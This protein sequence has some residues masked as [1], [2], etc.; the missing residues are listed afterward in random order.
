[1][2]KKVICEEVQVSTSEE[3]EFLAAIQPL[4]R[5]NVLLYML[6]VI[7]AAKPGSQIMVMAFTI[8]HGMIVR[9]LITAKDRGCGVRVLCDHKSMY[10]GASSSQGVAVNA[11]LRYGIEVMTYR[12]PKGGRNASLHAKMVIVSKKVLIMGSANFTHNSLDSCVE[13]DVCTKHLGT[14]EEMEKLFL[15]YYASSSHV[16]PEQLKQGT[17]W[18]KKRDGFLRVEDEEVVSA[19]VVTG[20]RSTADSHRS[21][22]SA[23]PAMD[24][25]AI[26]LQKKATTAPQD[27]STH[28]AGGE[29]KAKSSGS[30]KG[31]ETRQTRSRMLA[32]MSWCGQDKRHDKLAS[33]PKPH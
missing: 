26:V 28:H 33:N 8:D 21:E 7:D 10:Y 30:A 17:E 29:S 11:L 31:R 3:Y 15:E 13:A 6:R 19:A 18:S 1:M 16:I 32:S 20:Q 5:S 12:P 9:A 22:V 4:T 27:V 24:V 25:T 14:L 23:V 2:G